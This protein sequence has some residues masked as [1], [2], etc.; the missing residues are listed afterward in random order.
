MYEPRI[1][2]HGFR[3]VKVDGRTLKQV[4]LDDF[5]AIVIHSEMQRTRTFGCSDP[6]FNRLYKSIVWSM[7][8][9]FVSIPSDADLAREGRQA[10]RNWPVGAQPFSTWGLARAH[11]PGR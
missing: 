11:G 5:H 3:Y 6:M 9:N 4:D 8:G 10:R 1:I 2:F 7:K